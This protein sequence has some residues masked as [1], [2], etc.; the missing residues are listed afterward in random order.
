MPGRNRNRRRQHRRGL[1]PLLIPA[2]AAAFS[3]YVATHYAIDWGRQPSP[4]AQ[5]APEVAVAED[6]APPPVA[7]VRTPVPTLLPPTSPPLPSPRP[8]ALATRAATGAAAPITPSNLV[9]RV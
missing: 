8:T 9:A 7:L 6:V 1:G 2:V 4:I 5:I 3:I